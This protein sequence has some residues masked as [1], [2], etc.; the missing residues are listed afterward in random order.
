[1]KKTHFDVDAAHVMREL[2][3]VDRAGARDSPR[4]KLPHEEA[5]TATAICEPAS[6]NCLPT[7]GG[8]SGGDDFGR[9]KALGASGLPTPE[10]ILR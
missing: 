4:R 2:S 9:V 3:R 5:K 10:E 1:M 6:G 8:K 7:A